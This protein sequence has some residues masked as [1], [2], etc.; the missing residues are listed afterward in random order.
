MKIGGSPASR[1]FSKSTPATVSIGDG[2]TTTILNFSKWPPASWLRNPLSLF[3]L[4]QVASSRATTART[5]AVIRVV[6]QRS[7]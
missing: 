7:F 4:D 3:H 2:E 1:T 5:A 6:L